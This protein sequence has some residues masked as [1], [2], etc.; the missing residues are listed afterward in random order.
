MSRGL[1]VFWAGWKKGEMGALS[2]ETGDGG[3]R[4]GGLGGCCALG[5]RCV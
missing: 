1:P 2:D 4:A 5:D 3:G